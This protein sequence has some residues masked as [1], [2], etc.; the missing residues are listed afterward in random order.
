MIQ[1]LD[2]I[3]HKDSNNFFLIAGPCAIEGEDFTL[4][5]S[6]SG[7]NA[8]AVWMI[9]SKHGPFGWEEKIFILQKRTKWLCDKLS[10]LNI[11]FYRHKDANIVTIRS[12]HLSQEIAK[13]YWLV[14]DNQNNPTW[15]KIVVMEHVTIEKFIPLIND[16]QSFNK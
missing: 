4:I 2:K 16:L 7:A 13:K 11:E 9:L 10:E 15:F 1:F 14:P 6:R 8:I 5:G 3:K 12:K